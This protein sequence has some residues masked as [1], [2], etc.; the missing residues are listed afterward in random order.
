MGSMAQSALMALTLALNQFASS[1]VHAVDRKQG[2]S[3]SAA[4]KPKTITA[5]IIAR[6]GLVLSVGAYNPQL[7][8]S[9]TQLLRRYLKKSEENK[10]KNDKEVSNV[11]NV[12]I[13]SV[14]WFCRQVVVSSVAVWSAGGSSTS[15][16][17]NG[18]RRHEYRD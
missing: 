13:S 9:G 16:A 14:R 15:T 6:R 10:A 18:G 8:D 11:T 17:T 4:S 3:P 2:K 1:N 5:A 7:S 12:T